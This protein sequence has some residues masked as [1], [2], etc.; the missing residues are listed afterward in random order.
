MPVRYIL[1]YKKGE[2]RICVELLVIQDRNL[3]RI[4]LLMVL[5]LLSIEDMTVPVLRYLIQRQDSFLR[6]R[7][8]R[9]QNLRQQL[10]AMQQMQLAES[11][12][13]D[14]LLT[15]VLQKLMHILITKA[16]LLYVITESSRITRNSQQ[17]M[18]LRILLSL[19]QIQKS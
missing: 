8:E 17:S 13:Q 1:M 7:Q 5:R 14:G 16:Q 6:K 18:A 2:K 12:I 4:F 19:K 9:L 3:Q 10:P 15:E 11:D